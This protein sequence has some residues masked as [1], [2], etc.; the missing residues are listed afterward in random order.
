MCA[1]EFLSIFLYD[2]LKYV[3]KITELVKIMR[4]THNFAVQKEILDF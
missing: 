4:K 1:K 2:V 3:N